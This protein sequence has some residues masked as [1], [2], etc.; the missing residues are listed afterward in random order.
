MFK[1]IY[2][3]TCNLQELLTVSRVDVMSA[4]SPFQVGEWQL[5]VCLQTEK[6]NKYT[7]VIST[8]FSSQVHRKRF[9]RTP[10]RTR[11][12]LSPPPGLYL[13]LLTA[14]H[15]FAPAS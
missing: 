2:A 15:D 14:Q 13:H 9:G 1:I 10:S 8:P 6:Q 4:G 5:A 11:L 3:A 12:F 7:K